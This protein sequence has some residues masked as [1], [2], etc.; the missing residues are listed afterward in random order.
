MGAD[1]ERLV[2]SNSGIDNT[3]T[4]WQ[5]RSRISLVAF[6]MLNFFLSFPTTNLCDVQPHLFLNLCGRFKVV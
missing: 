1:S 3:Q 4:D 6:C 5:S 2:S